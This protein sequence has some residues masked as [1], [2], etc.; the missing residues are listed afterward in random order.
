MRLEEQIKNIAAEEKKAETV[1]AWSERD[2]GYIPICDI[3]L[4]S[5][6]GQIT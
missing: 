2:L 4:L 6:T 5:D 3:K 1:E